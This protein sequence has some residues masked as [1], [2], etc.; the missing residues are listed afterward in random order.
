MNSPCSTL[1][2]H[3]PRGSRAAFTLIELLVVIAIIAILAGMLLPALSRAKLK[4]QQIRCTSNLK[5]MSLAHFMYMNDQGKAIPYTQERDL[6]MAILIRNQAQVHQVRY[7]PSAPEPKRRISRNPANPNYGT[8]DETWIWPTNGNQGY[9]GSYV[10]NSW[11]YSHMDFISGEERNK[12]FATE[13]TINSPSRT[14]VFGDGMWVDAWPRATDKPARNLYE[15]DGVA[16]GIGRYSVA[17]HGGA[18][19]KTAPKKVPAGSRL[20]G[21]I[22]ISAA[23][24]HVE[25]VRLEDLWNLDWHRDYTKPAKRPD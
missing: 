25:L 7:C 19:A 6:W 18:S 20:P 1:L 5:Q 16:G 22:N 3:R 4:G 13:A 8:S 17:R 21:S 15:G 24:G 10:F 9:Q 23:D 14:P 11:H 2:F 12:I